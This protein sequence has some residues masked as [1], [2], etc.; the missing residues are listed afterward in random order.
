M[1]AA[2]AL[3]PMCRIL[4]R[5]EEDRPAVDSILYESDRLFVVP[6]LG[7][8]EV[9][10]VLL[11]TK[12]H[13]HSFAQ[14]GQA[15]L[16]E[17]ATFLATDPVASSALV[18]EH[19]SVDGCGGGACVDHAHLSILP[20]PQ[21]TLLDVSLPIVGSFEVSDLAALSTFASHPY[22][23]IRNPAA[24]V[25]ICRG[26]SIPSQLVRRTYASQVGRDDWDWAVFPADSTVLKTIEHWNG[27]H[28]VQH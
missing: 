9:G 21:G 1:D 7:P 25:E 14:A 19:G 5:R 2:L 16:E 27:L 12:D 20:V 17:A 13:V 15:T 3:C 4:R 6:A 18:S 11:V 8:L 23:L 24:S 26:D 22:V 28:N 10:H